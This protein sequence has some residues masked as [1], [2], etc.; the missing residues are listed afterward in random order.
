VSVCQKHKVNIGWLFFNCCLYINRLLSRR[1]LFY[2]CILIYKL[3]GLSAKE[4]LV[5]VCWLFNNCCLFINCQLSRHCLFHETLLSVCPKN[6]WLTY[7]DCT[8]IA[9]CS[10][11]VCW[12]DIVCFTN[13]YA[14]LTLWSVCLKNIRLTYDDCSTIAKCSSK[15]VVCLKI[16][17]QTY[18]EILEK[19]T[20]SFV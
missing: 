17:I 19:F 10:T 6:T 20:Y 13:V 15:I 4:H 9:I 18:K 1:C 16:W 7:T 14:Q 5:N 2:K 12:T 11:I 3:C 8:I